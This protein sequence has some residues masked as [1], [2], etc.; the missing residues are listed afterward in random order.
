MMASI[1]CK[2]FDNSSFFVRSNCKENAADLPPTLWI[3]VGQALVSSVFAVITFMTYNSIRVLNLNIH[4]DAISNTWW[5]VY[6]L[7]SALRSV[8]NSIKYSVDA[9]HVKALE[10][11]DWCVVDLKMLILCFAL[12]YQRKYRSSDLITM[13]INKVGRSEQPSRRIKLFLGVKKTLSSSGLVL[14]T[15]A[16]VTLASIIVSCVLISTDNTDKNGQQYLFWIYVGSISWNGLVSLFLVYFAMDVRSSE[17]PRLRIKIM[18][19]LAVLLS[20]PSDLPFHIWRNCIFEHTFCFIKNI[21][22]FY[23]CVVLLDVLSLFLFFLIMRREY[24]RLKQE[25]E[26]A[27]LNEVQRFNF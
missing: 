6:F 18:F 4:I 17:G 12:N 21:F 26:W 20:L 5:I 7:V 15:F 23:D 11:T 14:C 2:N 22:S 24:L 27:M 1:T 19:I 3:F 25:C 9:N 13:E 10:V 8:L 16:I